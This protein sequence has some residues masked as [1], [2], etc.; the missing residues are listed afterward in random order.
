MRTIL[1]HRMKKIYLLLIIIWGF[2]TLIFAQEITDPIERALKEVNLTK[3]TCKFDRLDMKNFGG[4]EFV[5]PVFTILHSDFFK[6][7][8][9][10]NEFK[11]AVA[12]NSNSLKELIGFSSRRVDEGVR[13]GLI[14]NPLEENLKKTESDEALYQAIYMLH[15]KM[16]QELSFE[17]AESLKVLIN[18][19]PPE[20]GRQVA[21]LIYTAFDSYKWRN[22]AFKKAE[23][24]FSVSEI[25]E[26]ATS[27]LTTEEGDLTPEFYDFIHHIDYRYLYTGAEDLALACDMAAD[28]LKK[29]TFEQ[30]FEF[31]FTTPLGKIVIN[32]GRNNFNEEND[33]F[34]LVDVGGDDLYKSGAASLDY[35]HPISLLIDLDGNDTY[36][37]IDQSPSFGAGV[38]GYGFLIDV[39]GDDRY[40]SRDFSLGCGLFGVGG[41]MD[42]EGKDMYDSY[43]TSQ[44]SGT[45]GIGILSDLEGDDSY[46]TFFCSQGFGFTKGMGI[47]VDMNG[48]DQYIANDS[49]I[50]FPSSQTK[51]HNTSMS[52]GV[53]FGWRADFTDG[54]SLAGGVGMLVDMEGD[55]SYQ[56]G[57]FAQGCAY[58]YS[59]GMLADEA[60]SD[61][62]S[63][64]W[65]VQGS[66]A[67]FGVGILNDRDGNDHYIAAMNMAQGAGHDFT[68]GY[69]LDESGDDVH[70]APNLSLG[71]GN[72]NGVGIFWD[73]S[74]NDVY[75]VEAATTLGRANIASRG[76][77][78]DHMLCLGLF[79]DTGGQ[80]KY[81]KPFAKNNLLW[82]QQGLNREF[83]LET[84][85]GVGLDTEI[86]E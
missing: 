49:T 11:N 58:W 79:L 17:E 55:D 34:I 81:S 15:C 21:L 52:Q 23:E 19:I 45:F 14:S 12:K 82:T 18:S 33:Y 71:G 66:G 13:R 29:L 35:D 61:N 16:D 28:S 37:S 25:Y 59:V 76:S 68:I 53:G 86:S 60:G 70:D 48:N 73:R 31:I 42:F 43:T 83:P 41:I 50:D 85:K 46:H 56:A 47:L 24:N 1:K 8:T 2:P 32:D 3:A 7:P 63:G 40:K 39:K 51:E 54:H 77:L 69:L 10:T 22:L 5:L 6:I 38:F 84:E 75:N 72:A 4:D 74:G 44:G 78:R 65:Y 80:D 67:H 64:I 36:E 9:Y 20:L 30:E 62:Y 57:L 26:Q 27:L